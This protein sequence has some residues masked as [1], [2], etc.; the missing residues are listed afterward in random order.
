MS[1]EYTDDIASRTFRDL[2]DSWVGTNGILAPS[3]PHLIDLGDSIQLALP[4]LWH[5]MP[6]INSTWYIHSSEVEPELTQIKDQH[7]TYDAY[8]LVIARDAMSALYDRCRGRRNIYLALAI[9]KQGQSN[10]L[11]Y[12]PPDRFHWYILDLT[13]YFTS[14]TSRRKENTILIPRH[15]QLNLSLFTL[16]WSSLWVQEFFLPLQS[17]ALYQQIDIL[18][19]INSVFVTQYGIDEQEIARQKS[20]ITSGLL[21][22]RDQLDG[23]QL[24]RI[25]MRLGLGIAMND[26][27]RRM[28]IIH[29]VETIHNYCPE[30]LYGTANM[31]LFSRK[32]HA[33]MTTSAR[34]APTPENLRLLPV[35]TDNI[36]GTPRILRCAVW[37]AFRFY[38]S[39]NVYVKIIAAPASAEQPGRD[40]NY[41][42]A[43]IGHFP[44][45]TISDTDLEID[46]TT[47]PPG[48]DDDN[49]DF[50]GYHAKRPI[51]EI[52]DVAEA[53][54]V[55]GIDR[56]DQLTLQFRRPT[57]LFPI[58]NDYLE[59]PRQ[60]WGAG[61]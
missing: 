25:S 6:P 52:D 31:W 60:L 23:E 56:V 47:S 44:W 41:Y 39:L 1:S 20:L 22:L 7:A 46:E 32:Y 61:A 29:N 40:R 10:I 28:S 2:V 34:V 49:R 9:R 35:V 30:A 55:L 36:H 33:Y 21:P 8:S 51:L 42:G 54:V 17:P 45:I 58:D 26:V 12:S 27:N 15:N 19:N 37:H 57:M 43:G 59:S 16:L 24:H 18:K 3:V 4:A 48:D 14:P 53:A 13:Q 5:E 38:R 50:L 11:D